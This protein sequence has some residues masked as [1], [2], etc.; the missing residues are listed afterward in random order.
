MFASSSTTR[1]RVGAC[2]MLPSC[3]LLLWAGCGLPVGGVGERL[4]AS[5]GRRPVAPGPRARGVARRE[6]LA[7][8]LVHEPVEVVARHLVVGRAARA[9]LGPR[10]HARLL[11]ESLARADV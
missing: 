4:G 6:R 1:T 2:S 3:P 7:A 11:R 10:R 5:A 8:L 9:G